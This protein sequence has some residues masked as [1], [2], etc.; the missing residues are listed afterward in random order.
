MDFNYLKN[1]TM[2]FLLLLF[3]LSTNQLLGQKEDGPSDAKEG[4]CYGLYYLTNIVL[5]HN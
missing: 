2:R 3:I 4:S 1:K 5:F